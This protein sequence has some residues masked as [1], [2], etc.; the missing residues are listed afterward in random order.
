VNKWWLAIGAAAVAVG[1]AFAVAI[2]L[3]GDVVIPEGATSSP[4]P[5][6]TAAN[7]LSPAYSW[8]GVIIMC[9]AIAT[10]VV[11]ALVARALERR[12]AR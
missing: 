4:V 10:M 6:M 2:A 3:P 12:R 7:W 5:T 1:A 9:A 11:I 8:R